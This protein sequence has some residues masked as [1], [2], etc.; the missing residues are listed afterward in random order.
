MRQ[1]VRNVGDLTEC[2]YSGGSEGDERDWWTRRVSL[3]V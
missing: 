2:T 3:I 1:D